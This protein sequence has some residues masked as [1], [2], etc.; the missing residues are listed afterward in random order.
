MSYIGVG[1]SL[2]EGEMVD[3]AAVVVERMVG[4]VGAVVGSF[5]S[6]LVVV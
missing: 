4:M 5:D 3:V 2:V 6:L 1:N